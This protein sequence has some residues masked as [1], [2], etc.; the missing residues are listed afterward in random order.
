MVT[1]RDAVGWLLVAA[2]LHLVPSGAG[3]RAAPRVPL[4]PLTDPVAIGREVLSGGR[5]S[6]SRLACLI[7]LEPSRLRWRIRSDFAADRTRLVDGWLLAETEAYLCAAVALGH[8]RP[9]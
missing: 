8:A 1:R 6:R 7:A 3:A 9:S 5:L 4:P 2:L